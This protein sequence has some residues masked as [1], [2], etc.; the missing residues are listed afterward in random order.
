MIQSIA[1]EFGRKNHMYGAERDDYVQELSIWVL[2]KAEKVSEWLDPELNDP[3]HG[4]RRIAL[5]LRNRAKDYTKKVKRQALGLTPAEMYEYG[6][7]EV[8]E[9]LKAMFHREEWL[10]PP[11]SDGRSTKAPAHGNNWIATLSD[12]SLAFDSL[13]GYDRGILITRYYKGRTL[14]EGAF[15]YGKTEATMSRH[16]TRAIRRIVDTLN[17]DRPRP[18]PWTGRRARS[19]ASMRAYEERAYEG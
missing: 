4:E 6:S 10:Y 2:E 17:G 13:D 12:V 8:E 9:L 3:E 15:L 5:S 18:N 16:V 19:T 14:A 11:K 7:G 1:T